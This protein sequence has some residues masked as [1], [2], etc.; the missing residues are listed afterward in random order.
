MKQKGG[1]KIRNRI[2][3]YWKFQLLG[4]GIASLDWAYILYFRQDCS[5]FHT[6][7]NFLLDVFKSGL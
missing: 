3:L 2:S 4:W 5:L 7:I 6:S 1:I